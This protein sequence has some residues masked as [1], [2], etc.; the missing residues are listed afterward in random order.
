MPSVSMPKYFILLLIIISGC[1]KTNSGKEPIPVRIRVGVLNGPSAVSIVKMMNNA[2]VSRDSTS[3]EFIVKSEPSQVKSMMFREEVEFAFLPSTTAA[4]LYN[5]GLNYQVAVIPLWGTMY[6]IGEDESVHS[7][8]DLKGK[9]VYQMGR[10]VTPDVVLRYILDKKGLIPDRD[11]KIDYSFP[12]HIDLAN[13]VKAGIA[14]LG[15]ISEPQVSMIISQNPRVKRLIDMTVEWN[16]ATH[17]SI[18]FAQ[19]FVVVNRTFAGKNQAMVRQ[20]LT[21][22]GNNIN[23]INENPD[24]AAGMLVRNKI[25]PDSSVA[26]AAIPGCNMKFVLAAK[27]KKQVKDYFD[28]FFRLNPDIIGGKVPDE[29]FFYNE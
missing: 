29:N 27:V 15:V 14:K 6:L 22:Y 7:L 18:P 1:G 5:M 23:W 19:T 13:A 24:L 8:S 17:D 20:F 3:I 4:I 11:V 16:A 28:I 25:L 21:D 12:S 9:T 26:Y 10:G 2:R